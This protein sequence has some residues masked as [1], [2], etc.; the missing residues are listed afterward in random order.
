[1]IKI[2]IHPLTYILILSTLLC[3][4][5]NYFIIISSIILLHDLGHIII[6]KY[7]N[8]E[9]YNICILPFGSIIK[10]KIDYNLNSNKLLLISSAGIIMQII[11]YLIFY[12]LLNINIIN[13]LSYNIF[14]YYNK[15][16]ILFNL[17]PIIPLDGSKIIMSLLERFLPYKLS[18]IIINCLSIICI[19]VFIF[20]NTVT[21]NILLI[22]SYLFIK[23]Y[24]EILN[25]KYIF[26]TFLLERYLRK[27]YFN[28]IN[29][30]N[31]IN[32]LYKNRFNFIKNEKETTFLA[33]MFDN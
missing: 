18:L 17:L 27:P 1:M 10:S 32:N 5:F 22:T 29:Y 31:S 26:N 7:F 14:L 12:I 30:V 16:I 3:G 25:H 13:E 20:N 15:I 2:I 6:M 4:Y 11:L 8:I 28:K 24:E 9:I 23:T 19:F 33:K 21:L